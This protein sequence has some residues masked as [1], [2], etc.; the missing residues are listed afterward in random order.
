MSERHESVKY[1][2]TGEVPPPVICAVFAIF[3]VC[4]GMNV[5]FAGEPWLRRFNTFFWVAG[6]ISMIGILA[7]FLFNNKARSVLHTQRESTDD[8]YPV[9]GQKK[10]YTTPVRPDVYGESYNA[11]VDEQNSTTTELTIRPLWRLHMVASVLT[12][13][14]LILMSLTLLVTP[15]DPFNVDSLPTVPNNSIIFFSSRRYLQD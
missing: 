11:R 14:V 8:K 15:V 1:A 5:A 6:P 3:F 12:L 13:A 7:L 2:N 9:V 10:L 4:V